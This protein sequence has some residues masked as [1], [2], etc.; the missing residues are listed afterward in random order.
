MRKMRLNPPS[1]V[2]RKLAGIMSRFPYANH[3]GQEENRPQIEQTFT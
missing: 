2:N 1:D 3:A